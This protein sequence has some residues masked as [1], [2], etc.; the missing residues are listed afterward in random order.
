ML[1]EVGDRDLDTTSVRQLL[2]RSVVIEDPH[3]AVRF[4]IWSTEELPSLMRELGPD[5]IDVRAQARN[6]GHFAIW[7][8]AGDL[9][10]LKPLNGLFASIPAKT[11]PRRRC[12]RLHQSA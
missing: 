3:S 11:G 6:G 10:G 1:G 2:D 12:S 5:A 8:S 9:A 4:H 7:N